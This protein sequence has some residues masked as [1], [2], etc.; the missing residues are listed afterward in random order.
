MN[1]LQ[2]FPFSCTARY[3]K[4]TQKAHKYSIGFLRGKVREKR[5]NF[6][7]GRGPVGRLAARVKYKE[8]KI[9]RK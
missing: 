9:G 6:N 2:I 5:M 3:T 4:Q 7:L 1:F 8:I